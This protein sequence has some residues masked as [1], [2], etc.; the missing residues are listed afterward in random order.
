MSRIMLSR[1]LSSQYKLNFVFFEKKGSG[2]RSPA[3]TA[4]V[5]PAALTLSPSCEAVVAHVVQPEWDLQALFFFFFLPVLKGRKDGSYSRERP[6]FL[7]AGTSDLPQGVI[8]PTGCGRPLDGAYLWRGGLAVS[9]H[10]TGVS[11]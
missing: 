8:I 7:A 3:S 5:I 9:P 10:G 1:F 11:V 2:G 4:K 6:S